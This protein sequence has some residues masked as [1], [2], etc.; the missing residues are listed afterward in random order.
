M[1]LLE[2]DEGSKTYIPTGNAILLFGK[3]P[4]NKFPQASIKAKVHYGDGKTGT[5]TFKDALVLM[6]DKVEDWIKKVLPA[7]IDRSKFK[8]QQVPSFPI[9]VIREAVINALAHRDYTIEGAKIQ[10]DVFPDKI[11]IKTLE[12]PFIQFH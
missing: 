6:P 2:Y 5:E 4:R 12:S 7:S 8:A 1:E 10:I 3:N 11:I 9:E